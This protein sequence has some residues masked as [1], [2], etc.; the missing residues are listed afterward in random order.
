MPSLDLIR[1]FLDSSG[2]P[3]SLDTTGF[4]SSMNVTRFTVNLDGQGG[5]DSYVV[6][7]TGSSDY[8]VNVHDSGQPADGVDTLTINGNATQ[9]NVFLIRQLFVALM[10]PIGDPAR[11]YW[12]TLGE[13][14]RRPQTGITYQTQNY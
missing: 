3:A 8:I 13:V 12:D 5:G 1:K 4:D 10:Q 14:D 11:R 6:N 2:T 7:M 9:S